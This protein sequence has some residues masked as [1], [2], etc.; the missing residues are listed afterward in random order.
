MRFGR[1]LATLTLA[2]LAVLLGADTLWAQ[3]ENWPPYRPEWNTP[4]A[5]PRGSGWYLGEVRVLLAVLMLLLWVRTGEWINDDAQTAHMHFRRWN[6]IHLAS[7]FVAFLL[8][9]QIPS[10]WLSFSLLV[11]AYGVPLGIYVQ[12]RNSG[13]NPADKVFTPNHIRYVAAQQLKRFGV[14]I[15]TEAP[16]QVERGSPIHLQARA[17]EDAEKSKRLI[18]AR[19]LPGYDESRIMLA[20]ALDNR[21]GALMLDYGASAVAVRH[22]IDGVWLEAPER[23]RPSSDAALVSLKT[24]CG[25]DPEERRERQAGRF[26]AED[27]RNKKLSY[28]CQFTSQGTKTGERVLIQF[29]DG[30]ASHMRLPE[31]GMRQSLQD[32][33]K[34]VMSAPQG[35]IVVSAPSGNGLTALLNST[36][37]AIDRYMRSVVVVEDADNPSIHVE[38]VSPHPYNA[39]AGQTPDSVLPSV[40]RQYPD[41]MIVPELVNTETATLLVNEAADGKLIVVGVRAKDA[42]EALLRVMTLKVPPKKYAAAVA[43]VVNQ[44]LIRKL[45]PACKQPYTPSQNMLEKLGIPAD[46]VEALYRPPEGEQAEAC[47]Q[48]GSLRYRG[49][50]GIFE[51]LVV[52]N[53]VRQTLLTEPKLDAVR[54]AAKKAGMTSLQDEGLALVVKGDT[55]LAELKRVLEATS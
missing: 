4:E 16:V 44:R 23:E 28:E 19:H 51:L 37:A 54:R 35:L 45:C 12:Q 9:W 3:A 1:L 17:K 49:R 11:L 43:A 47:P 39:A 18:A 6:V 30:S 21:A 46:R 2:A 41:V 7:F 42:A 8:M 26:G 5:F 48:C 13:R 22:H 34:E 32:Q 33:L 24:L 10:F 38:N 50:T 27:E 52:S 15:A 29:D 40:I 14:N 55:S 25:L 31:S 36:A 20:E 53:D